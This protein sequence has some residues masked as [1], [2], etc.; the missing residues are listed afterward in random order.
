MERSGGIDSG[1]LPLGLSPEGT[2]FAIASA[3]RLGDAWTLQRL[4]D[5]AELESFSSE[6]AGRRRYLFAPLVGDAILLAAHAPL[7][8]R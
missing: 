1:P 8:S 5:T 3:R 6:L 7:R 4:L 2:G